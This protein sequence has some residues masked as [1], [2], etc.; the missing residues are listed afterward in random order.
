MPKQLDSLPQD[1]VELRAASQLLAAGVKYQA[2]MIEKL[3]HQLAGH[4]RHR[5]GSTGE[6]LDQPG[7][8][9]AGDEQIAEAAAQ[10]TPPADDEAS[11]KPSRGHGR[12]A[13]PG[14]L[15]RREELLSPGED[16]SKCGASL[17]TLGEDVTEQLEYVPGRF[18]VKKI[19]RPRMACTCCEAI[20]QAPLPS[21]PVER[22]RP[23]PGLLAHVLVSKYADHLPLYRQSQ[24]YARESIE[25]D[26]SALA[27][28]VG[29]SA[30]LPEPLA[31]AIG[32]CDWQACSAGQ[33][34]L[35][36]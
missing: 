36:R 33:G 26:R 14:H 23:G 10:K 7:L 9:F 31:G 18:I 30:A 35:C 21:R 16:C 8:S 13:L 28:R 3:E 5:F 29:K 27:D 15:E 12:K 19:I 32:R 11:D 25:L 4:N 34:Y 24:I 17:K 20:V 6:S 2:L 22:G 1:P